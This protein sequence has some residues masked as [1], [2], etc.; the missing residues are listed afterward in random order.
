MIDSS[1][2]DKCVYANYFVIFFFTTQNNF[3]E[4]KQKYKNSG[5]LLF[6]KS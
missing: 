3:F 5:T 4:I 2:F 6:M 1:Q